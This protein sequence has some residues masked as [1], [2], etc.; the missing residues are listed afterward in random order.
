MMTKKKC[1]FINPDRGGCEAWAMADSEF[2][3]FHNPDISEVEKKEAQS[4]GGQANKI[5][6]LEPLEPIALKEGKDVVLLLE[7][8]INKVR[9]G[10]MDL[11][12][13]NCIGYLAGHLIKAIETAKLED[14]VEIIERAVLEKR[15]YRKL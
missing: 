6:I 13:A 9:A 7:D 10:E 14:R 4:R 3:F 15:S 2:C 5:K 12:V 8:T 1:R 11:K